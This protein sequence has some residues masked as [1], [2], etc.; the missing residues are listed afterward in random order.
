MN[1]SAE[2]ILVADDDP[3]IQEALQDRLETLGY[4][5][6]LAADGQQALEI[7]EHQ[8]PQ[9]ILL[10]IEMP[11]MKGLDVLKEIRRRESD[12]PVIMITAYGSIDL[13]VQAMKEGAY[14][15]IP[16]PFDPGHVALVVEKA[17]E[18]QRLRRRSTKCFR[19]RWTRAIC[20]IA[21]KSSKMNP[22]IDAAKKAAASK[23]TVLLLG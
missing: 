2:T 6:S 15:F 3:Y 10:D 12:I 18:R 21:G 8:D 22:A 20:L 11:G 16:K 7:L 4:R 5:V 19:K 1:L 17:M 13:A 23:S 14:D 9:L